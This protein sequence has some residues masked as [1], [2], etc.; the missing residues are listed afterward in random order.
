MRRA[1]ASG[2]T[3]LTCYGRCHHELKSCHLYWC[4]SFIS[5]VKCIT[6]TQKSQ[7]ER[8]KNTKPF[9]EFPEKTAKTGG[10][11][12]FPVPLAASL[13]LTVTHNT[14]RLFPSP[15]PTEVL[16]RFIHTIPRLLVGSC[17]GVYQGNE[18]TPS[19]SYCLCPGSN[20]S[21]S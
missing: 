7:I 10:G 13:D 17:E 16:V 12:A 4:D 3:E 2:V 15:N 11:G 8:D 5:H 9:P 18:F 14:L 19:N 20:R 21:R 6:V 1:K